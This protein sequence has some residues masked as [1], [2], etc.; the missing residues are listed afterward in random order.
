MTDDQMALL[1]PII[2]VVLGLT[3]AAIAV[4]TEHQ[5]KIKAAEHRHAE[6]MAAIE[7]GLELP[8][9]PVQV[10]KQASPHRYLLRGLVW[11]GVGLAAALAVGPVVGEKVAR[12]GW[13]AAA[14]G[15]AFLI[16]YAVEMRRK[17]EPPGTLPW[18]DSN[19]GP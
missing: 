5:R 1:I 6:R 9:D 13:V 8:P 11:L 12:L 17:P 10:P 19:R 4:I 18:Q 15:V 14:V 3:V 16:F 7:K 2:S